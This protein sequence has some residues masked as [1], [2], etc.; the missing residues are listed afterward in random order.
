MNYSIYKINLSK[1]FL[2]EISLFTNKVDDNNKLYNIDYLIQNESY[3]QPT[4]Q[5]KY[6]KSLYKYLTQFN[7]LNIYKIILFHLNLKNLKIYAT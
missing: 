4:I 3:Y 1:N 6:K 2:N 7:D 5:I